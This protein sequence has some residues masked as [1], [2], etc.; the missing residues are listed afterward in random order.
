MKLKTC[1]DLDKAMT[2]TIE[3]EAYFTPAASVSNILE[4]SNG[5]KGAAK[6]GSEATVHTMIATE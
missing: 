5:H 4:E 2:A 3:L 6:R 1:K